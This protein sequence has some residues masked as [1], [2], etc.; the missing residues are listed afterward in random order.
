M[1]L[2]SQHALWGQRGVLSFVETTPRPG[3]GA[4]QTDDAASRV[5]GLTTTSASTDSDDNPKGI[6]GN[7]GMPIAQDRLEQLKRI[8]RS[9][10]GH[11]KKADLQL[12]DT[13][14]VLNYERTEATGSDLAKTIATIPIIV[15]KW[16]TQ[17]K[18]VSCRFWHATL[19]AWKV[20]TDDPKGGLEATAKS[21]LKEIF[22]QIEQNRDQPENDKS[23][24]FLEFGGT[25][26]GAAATVVSDCFSGLHAGS[27]LIATF[28]QATCLPASGNFLKWQ[29]RFHQEGRMKYGESGRD[30][31]RRFRE[32]AQL[33]AS[34]R[35]AY[36]QDASLLG[37]ATSSTGALMCTQEP[38]ISRNAYLQLYV[39]LAQDTRFHH[40][41]PVRPA[42]TDPQA[43]GR[44]NRIVLEAFTNAC[45]KLFLTPT[46][47]P[48]PLK[49]EKRNDSRKDDSSGQSVQ[50]VQAF[51]GTTDSARGRTQQ[52][53]GKGK[54]G[55]AKP[56]PEHG[57]LHER[58][59]ASCGAD[60]QRSER[61]GQ[62][63][64]F[65]EVPQGHDSVPR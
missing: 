64:G 22:D 31:I 14:S 59:E 44:V 12:R 50:Q 28:I 39:E 6:I 18:I 58:G 30:F 42:Q 34:A 8:A 7:I 63:R 52:R 32:L 36:G 41:W 20:M 56:E 19:A 46:A 51:S 45:D 26:G 37:Y 35:I 61:Q 10:P 65:Q 13:D 15:E 27:N 49:K 29:L 2:N 62:G 9:H 4:A 25:D 1:V 11:E 17:K 54:G 55:G 24:T 57:G 60:E 43:I 47:R 23:M 33:S 5:S 3:S 21:R 53:N 48:A 38:Y 16:L 40:L